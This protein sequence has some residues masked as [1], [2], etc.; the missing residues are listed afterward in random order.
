M[1]C[2]S[3]I[4][5]PNPWYGKSG[6][7]S[8][9]HDTISHTMAIPC[10]WCDSCIS[11]RQMYFVQRV[12]MEA[13]YNHL[14][15]LTLTYNNAHLPILS[16]GDYDIPYAN[17]KHFVDMVKRIRERGS[18]SRPW[19]YLVVS[20]FGG[21]KGRP[22]FHALIMLPKEEGDTYNTCLQFQC[23]LKDLFLKEWSINVGSKRSPKYEP[24]CTYVSK[25]IRGKLRS[26]FDFHYVIPGLTKS[27]VSDCAFYVLKYMLKDSDRSRRLQQALRL[28]YNDADYQRIWS[29]VKPKMVSSKGFGLNA[30]RVDSTHY[31]FDER[32]INYLRDG[33][34]QTPSGSPYPFFY[35][36]DS[37]LTFPLAPYYKSFGRIYNIVDAHDFYFNQSNDLPEFKPSWQLIKQTDD[38]QKKLSLVQS[39]DIFNNFNDFDV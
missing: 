29:I 13:Q 19:R 39:E 8:Y 33:I 17:I 34:K 5:K 37:I 14:F 36:P 21:L 3:P 27:G 35:A 24:L 38:F 16:I 18:I 26:N 4:V 11:L 23:D 15:M 12:Q 20:E 31:E 30:R 10:G 6:G 32:I 22:H 28:N 25:I 7:F 9:L 1:P 2:L